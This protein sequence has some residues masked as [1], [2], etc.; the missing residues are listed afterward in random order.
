MTNCCSIK[1]EMTK[2]GEGLGE[3][4]RRIRGERD[5]T[6]ADLAKRL[7]MSAANISRIEHGADFRVSTLLDL[8][9]DLRY[10]PLLVPKPF[11]P[12]VRALI[13]PDRD[14]NA[15]ERGRFT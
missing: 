14:E 12:A 13:D 5:I 9:R 10:E 1:Q 3:A 4:L 15:V 8:A 2:W 11:V 6:Q 7:G